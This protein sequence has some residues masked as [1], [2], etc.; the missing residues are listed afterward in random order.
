[1]TAQHDRA[2]AFIASCI[3]PKQLK[4][5]MQNA[6][7]RGELELARAAFKKLVSIVP[8]ERPGT[9]EHDFWQ[10]VQ[11]TEHM[12]SDKR[13]KTTR[14]SASQRIQQ[15]VARMSAC[16]IRECRP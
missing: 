16:E 12:L 9:V 2:Q 3:D 14:L 15:A 11:A 6:R 7:G 5:M 10:A 8:S 13:G 1:M 4:T